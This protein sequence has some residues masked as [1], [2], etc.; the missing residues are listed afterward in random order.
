MFLGQEQ[1]KA[2]EEDDSREQEQRSVVGLVRFFLFSIVRRSSV[3]CGS[4]HRCSPGSTPQ[5]TADVGIGVSTQSLSNTP[6]GHLIRR[7]PSW[8]FVSSMKF[9][10]RSRS[11]SFSALSPNP[12]RNMLKFFPLK[13]ALVGRSGACSLRH[14]FVAPSRGVGHSIVQPSEH[15]SSGISSSTYAQDV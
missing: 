8:R 5:R 10:S 7:L 3:R 11:N 1:W 12:V 9:W 4:L 6:M 15:Q 2:I 14:P 13:A